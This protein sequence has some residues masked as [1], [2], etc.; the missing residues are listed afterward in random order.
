MAVREIPEIKADI[1]EIKTATDTAVMAHYFQEPDVTDVADFTGD[2]FEIARAAAQCPQQRVV[3]CAVRY[4]AETAKLLA[5][6]KDIILAHPQAFCPISGQI[7]PRRVRMFKEDNPDC[8]VCA[9]IISSTALK[10]EADICVTAENAVRVIERTGSKSILFLPDYNFGQRLRQKL[11]GVTIELWTGSCPTMAGVRPVDIALAREK[12]PGAAVAVSGQCS[13]EVAEAADFSGST[14]EIIRFCTESS[15]DVI[16]G[17]E[18]SVCARLA[19]QFPQR[20]FHQLAPSKLICNSM[21][22]CNLT[23]LER[24][25]KGEFGEHIELDPRIAAP[26]KTALERMEALSGEKA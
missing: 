10:A 2:S 20:G 7:N 18:C 21:S 4:I 16:I 14:G 22:L 24:A 12:W 5:P 11:P 19:R 26:A 8:C 6:D 25:L 13:P 1:M 15:G 9:F 17:E 23:V 3:I